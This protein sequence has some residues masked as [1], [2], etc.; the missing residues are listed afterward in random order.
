MHYYM[1]S[2]LPSLQTMSRASTC[3][4][5]L[6][7]PRTHLPLPQR[8]DSTDFHLHPAPH[9][10]MLASYKATELAN[11]QEP[12]TPSILCSIILPSICCY[13]CNP[14]VRWDLLVA[15]C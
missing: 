6:L 4:C 11:Q 9:H 12:D 14:L 5:N 3:Q 10:I 13:A 8:R 15:L 7:V 1:S 2:L